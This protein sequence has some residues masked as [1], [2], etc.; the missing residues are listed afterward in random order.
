MKIQENWLT[1]GANVVLTENERVAKIIGI[2][3]AARSTTVKPSGTSSLVLGTSS[4]I[5]AWHND[6]Y[7]RRIRVNKNESIYGYLK[8]YHP[9]LIEDEYFRPHDT[10]VIGIPMKAPDG[11]ITRT[12]SVFDLLER[13]K[14][15]N[16]DWVYTGHRRGPNKNNVSATISIKPDEWSKV[17]QWMWDNRENY[18]GIS[19][20]PYDGGTYIQAPFE[21]ITREQYLELSETLGDIDLSM[22]V[23]ENDNTDLSGEAACAGGV[24]EIV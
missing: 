17:G 18:C 23:E 19:V 15:Y 12:E 16:L 2:N 10:A 20:L 14:T 4:G 7:I 24:C 5:H 9:N 21:D 22:V 11:A 6:Y 13:V 1:N 8:Q 3:V